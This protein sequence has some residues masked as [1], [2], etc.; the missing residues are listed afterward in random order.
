VNAGPAAPPAVP[1]SDAARLLAAVECFAS[2]GA[3][4]HEEIAAHMKPCAAAAGETIVR[5]GE[6]ADR[7]F[8][9]AAGTLEVSIELRG[10]A[11]PVA[12]LGP[13]EYFGEIALLEQGG[14]RTATVTALEPAA[15]LSLSS[16]DFRRIVADYPAAARALRD[17]AEAS[18]RQQLLK[19]A[20]PFAPLP[21]AAARAL[22]ERLI[23]RSCAAGETVVR[24]NEPGDTCYLIRSG[25]VE[26]LTGEAGEEARRIA[27]LGPGDLFGESA[28]LTGGPRTATVRA[29]EP[30]ELLALQRSD[31]LAAAWHAEETGAR[32]VDLVRMRTRPRRAP[33][34]VA[35]D[36]PASDGEAIT[37]LTNPRTGRYFQL[38]SHGR[39]LWDRLDGSH[40]IRDIA[41]DYFAVHRS[42][43]FDGILDV[44]QG[45]ATAGFVEVPALRGDVPAGESARPRLKRV[46]DAARRLI[47]WRVGTTG[48]DR[49][50][51]KLYRAG[52]RWLTVPAGTA[53]LLAIAAAG[54]ASLAVS[55]PGAVATLRAT[56]S[57][58]LLVLLLVPMQVFTTLVH[59]AGHALA[60]KHF[61]RVVRS[62]G[63][64][65]YWYGPMA[66]IDTS[67]M[68][69]CGRWPRIAVS[70]AGPIAS[71]GLGGAAAL[72]ALALPDGVASV[73][74]LQLAVLN[75]LTA[76]VN[77]NPLLE[78]DGY[79]V[80]S[81]LLERPHLRREALGWIGR[82]LPAAL[83]TPGELRRHRVEL[84]Y[85]AAAVAWIV[86]MSVAILAVYRLT[87]RDWLAGMLSPG[88]ALAVAWLVAAAATV[89]P[90]FAL[91]SELHGADRRAAG[92]PRAS[93]PVSTPARRR[94]PPP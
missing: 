49:V 34:V 2:V 54:C 60:V 5:E 69:P 13:G 10:R 73:V 51:A 19:R 76:A 37:V 8:V 71:A 64:G 41:A 43:A 72:L 18:L 7:F 93:P 48:A 40:T 68:W 12:I 28:L 6:G 52:G 50:T 61:G 67:D 94:I 92:G 80:L 1:P 15:L 46:L 87:L 63:V 62:A 39:F 82:Q 89:L 29:T 47:D 65:W 9:V 42:F 38:S 58:L 33:G 32:L 78:L 22:A 55:A 79:Y 85:G 90:V 70:L 91:A 81:D 17:V 4:A 3:A 16:D 53:A 59:E 88:A 66:F 83:R 23:V 56:A 74:L 30:L 77:L 25:R 24:Q 45:L 11:A 26:V 21:P 44:L 57:P 35:E 84:L 36:R 75:F 31:L 14:R 27:T 86:L 20:S